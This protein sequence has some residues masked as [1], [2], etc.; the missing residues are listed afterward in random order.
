VL[1]EA[2]GVKVFDF[3]PLDASRVGTQ[4]NP[5]KVFSWVSLSSLASYSYTYSFSFILLRILS[6]LL[7]ALARQ[8]NLMSSSGS[9]LQRILSL[10]APN[11]VQVRLHIYTRL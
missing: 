1:G 5:V 9:T 10:A 3:E 2:E 7:A 11:V 8:P 6:V 4:E